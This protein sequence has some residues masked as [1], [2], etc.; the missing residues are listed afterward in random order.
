MKSFMIKDHPRGGEYLVGPTAVGSRTTYL[1]YN[2]VAPGRSAPLKSAAGHEEILLVVAGRARVRLGG[3]EAVF[4]AG[5]GA[6]LGEAPDGALYADGEETV[7]FICAGGHVP[8]AH[9]H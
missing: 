6:Y 3:E 5:Q 7:R 4:E 8:G 2:E 1:V 9:H